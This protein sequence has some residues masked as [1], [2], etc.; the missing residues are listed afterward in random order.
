MPR[1]GE[2]DLAGVLDDLSDVGG[3]ATATIGAN[4]TKGVLRVVDVDAFEGG[5][6]PESGTNRFVTIRTGSLAGLAVGAT[7]T[8]DGTP[9][10]VV[11]IRQIGNGTLTR[12]RVAVASGT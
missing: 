5:D 2:T 12:V 11:D 10:V 1:L 3:A 6:V 7:M 8:V 4:S 9:Y